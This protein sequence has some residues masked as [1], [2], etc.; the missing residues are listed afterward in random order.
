MI[1]N[2]PYTIIKCDI[3]YSYKVLY[4]RFIDVITVMKVHKNS[5]IK[6]WK[7]LSNR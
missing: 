2:E 6:Q 3:Y 1:G 5:I 7:L 4:K